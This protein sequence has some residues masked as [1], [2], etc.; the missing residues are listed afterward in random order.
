ME[1]VKRILD[2]SLLWRALMS[3]C[4]WVERQWQGSA[5]V[6][7]F[8]NPAGWSPAVSRSSI[9]YKIWSAEWSFLPI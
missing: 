3:L 2:A 6:R 9:F 8:L 1:Q 5:V 7:W 4:D